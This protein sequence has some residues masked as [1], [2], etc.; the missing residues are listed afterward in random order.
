MLSGGLKWGMVSINK[1][2][3]RS[4]KHGSALYGIYSGSSHPSLISLSPP[5]NIL[6]CLP[7]FV[8]IRSLRPYSLG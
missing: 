1:K 4:G 8:I 6:P 2:V 5:V 7:F 3:S